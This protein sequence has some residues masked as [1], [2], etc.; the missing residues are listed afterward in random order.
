MRVHSIPISLSF[1]YYESKEISCQFHC[2]VE[3][4]PSS[5]WMLRL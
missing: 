1:V 4:C 3:R 2:F 5:P